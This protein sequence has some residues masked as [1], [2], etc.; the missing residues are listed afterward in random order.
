MIG[1]SECYDHA[2]YERE[3]K[4]RKICSHPS[5]FLYCKIGKESEENHVI[6]QDNLSNF[7]I[8]YL[9]RQSRTSWFP[10]SSNFF[11]IGEA[12]SGF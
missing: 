2:S 3:K 4:K 8:L 12:K 1:F 7:S 9:E 11:T 6:Y 5:C 10:F